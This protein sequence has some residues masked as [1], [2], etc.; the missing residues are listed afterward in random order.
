[1]KFFSL[2]LFLVNLQVIS[3]K[4]LCTFALERIEVHTEKNLKE[5]FSKF[6]I[7][8]SETEG[9]RGTEKIFSVDLTHKGHDVA[10]VTFI[11][12]TE[13]DTMSL[14]Y[15]EVEEMYQRKKLSSLLMARALEKF[16]YPK[17]VEAKFLF[18]NEEAY[19][20]AKQNGKSSVDAVKET[21]F[22]K[23]ISEYG[24]TEVEVLS[25][26]PITVRV[27]NAVLM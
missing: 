8:Y 14:Y 25:E 1:M 27:Y 15:I 16:S 23:S 21:P 22:Y 12:D 10:L 19:R 18:D 13:K 5:A 4:T 3:A 2:V 9:V 7:Y 17:V 26:K 20:N 24:Y 6:D 11:Y